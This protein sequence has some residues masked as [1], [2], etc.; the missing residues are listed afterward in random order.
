[1]TNNLKQ[2]IAERKWR[3]ISERPKL[4]GEQYLTLSDNYLLPTENVD[5][6]GGMFHHNITCHLNVDDHEPVSFMPLPDDTLAD[7]ALELLEAIEWYASTEGEHYDFSPRAVKAL[8]KV[9]KIME[10]DD[11]HQD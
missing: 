8:N 4:S 5:N 11:V 1:M 10:G 9:N 2:F 7:I 6:E 3:D